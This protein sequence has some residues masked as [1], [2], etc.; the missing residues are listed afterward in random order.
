VGKVKIKVSACAWPH[1]RSGHRI[2]TF[3]FR[4]S[5]RVCLREH[6]D[7]MASYLGFT[8]RVYPDVLGPRTP[9]QDAE[10]CAVA[11]KPDPC[12]GQTQ[13]STEVASSSWSW[14][15]HRPCSLR[16]L[17][18]RMPVSASWLDGRAIRGLS[19]GLPPRLDSDPPRPSSSR[20]IDR[21]VVQ[22]KSTVFGVAAPEQVRVRPQR[23]VVIV[24]D[25]AY[26]SLQASRVHTH[27]AIKT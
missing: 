26:H 21:D 4:E 22:D 25:N 10:I 7:R 2:G 8:M 11:G 3:G 23:W 6:D 27:G 18:T 15:L 14:F 17:T 16:V 20:D 1:H 13:A 9:V 5:D 19:L 12:Q 24:L